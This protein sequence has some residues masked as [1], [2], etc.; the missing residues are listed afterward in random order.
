M[1]CKQPEHDKAV[2]L[3]QKLE[4]SET[5]HVMHCDVVIKMLKKN[6]QTRKHC[7]F[8]VEKNNTV[9]VKYLVLAHTWHKY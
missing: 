6:K 9:D 7:I 4:K 3:V 5:G 8:V 1:H 2:I